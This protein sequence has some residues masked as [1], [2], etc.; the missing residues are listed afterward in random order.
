MIFIPDDGK[1]DDKKDIKKDDKKK[2]KVCP[3]CGQTIGGKKEEKKDSA[4]EHEHEQVDPRIDTILE[5]LKS[6]VSKKTDSDTSKWNID[7]LFGAYR[8]LGS[9]KKDNL[10]ADPPKIKKKTDSKGN[11]II[12]P[13]WAERVEGKAIGES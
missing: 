9:I 7:E 12:I 11:E 3:T 10:L 2:P 13:E 6:E 5:F 1:K 8:V 4:D